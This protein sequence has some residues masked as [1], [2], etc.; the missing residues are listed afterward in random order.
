MKQ[1]TD[2]QYEALCGLRL[3]LQC[4]AE[5]ISR[6]GGAEDPDSIT[7]SEYLGYKADDLDKILLEVARLNTT[8]V[9]DSV[10]E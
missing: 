3:S 4:C 5:S 10:E 8:Q 9:A 7:F 1:I 2:K 6:I